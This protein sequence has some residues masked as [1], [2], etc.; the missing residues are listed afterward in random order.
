MDIIMKL[1]F[2]RDMN[3]TKGTKETAALV[4]SMITLSRSFS[5]IKHFPILGTTLQSFPNAIL[6]RIIPGFVEFR[7]VSWLWVVWFGSWSSYYGMTNSANSVAMCQ[8][9]H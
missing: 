9:G 1:C 6:G 7:K 8:M 2:G 4:E 5:L 3:C